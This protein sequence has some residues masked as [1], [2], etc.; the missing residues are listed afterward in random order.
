MSPAQ[1]YLPLPA[2]NPP[3]GHCFAASTRGHCLPGMTKQSSACSF[4]GLPAIYGR[5]KFVAGVSTRVRSLTSLGPVAAVVDFSVPSYKS[6]WYWWNLDGSK[7]KDTIA[8]HNRVYGPNFQYA[9]RFLFRFFC[10]GIVLC[11]SCNSLFCS[12]PFY[13]HVFHAID[14]GPKFTAELFDANEWADLFAQSGLKYIVLTS[15]HHEG[16]YMCVFASKTSC[17]PAG[18]PS[19]AQFC[20]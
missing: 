1:T 8:F 20:Y 12:S 16:L 5:S 7:D 6:E 17:E 18:S 4:T 13:P 14:F 19:C 2:L 3:C 9:G 11:L 10:F 15:K